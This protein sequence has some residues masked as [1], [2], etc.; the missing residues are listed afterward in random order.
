[1]IDIGC[2]T[3][4]LHPGPVKDR[5][6]TLQDMGRRLAARITASFTLRG[7]RAIQFDSPDGESYQALIHNEA[8]DAVDYLVI[9][10]VG[11]HEH[12]FEAVNVEGEWVT[13]YIDRDQFDSILSGVGTVL[14]EAV[15]ISY[16]QFVF[17]NEGAE[18]EPL[19]EDEI[20]LDSFASEM[21]HRKIMMS[22]Q[23]NMRLAF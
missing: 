6:D 11:V 3:K 2:V 22:H 4:H 10:Q 21:S 13:T 14:L 15:N 20:D 9:H 8:D 23:G 19:T 12:C 16:G 17:K 1:M 18:P 5:I 7:R